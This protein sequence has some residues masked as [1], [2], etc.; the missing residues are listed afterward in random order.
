MS[1]ICPHCGTA[2]DRSATFCGACATQMVSTSTALVATRPRSALPVLSQRERATLGSVA[3]GVAAVAVRVG[4]ALIQQAAERKQQAAAPVRA[5]PP[6]PQAKT[7]HVVVR[8][9]WVTS[10]G[11]GPVRWGEE[12]IEIEDTGENPGPYTITFKGPR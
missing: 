1:R 6:T 4:M 7:R 10:D 12:E 8:R 5:A 11:Y 9:R 3:V 2:N